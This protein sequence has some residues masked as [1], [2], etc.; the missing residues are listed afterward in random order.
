MYHNLWNIIQCRK[1]WRFP[2]VSTGDL[3]T[4]FHRFLHPFYSPCFCRVTNSRQYSAPLLKSRTSTLALK[5][6]NP[7]NTQHFFPQVYRARMQGQCKEEP[8]SSHLFQTTTC[9]LKLGNQIVFCVSVDVNPSCPVSLC[10]ITKSQSHCIKNERHSHL[11]SQRSYLLKF[12][13]VVFNQS[14]AFGMPCHHLPVRYTPGFRSPENP[15]SNN[16]YLHSMHV[17]H[18]CMDIHSDR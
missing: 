11:S 9:A 7:G 10:G 13:Q 4:W 17:L 5:E 6:V 15:N 2:S 1:S 14:H 12:T 16:A 18:V 3:L 8:V